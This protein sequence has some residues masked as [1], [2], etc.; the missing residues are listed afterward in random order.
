MDD[1]LTREISNLDIHIDRTLC[2]G[3]GNCVNVAPE[4]F[5]IDETNLVAFT[6]DTPDIEQDRLVEACTVCPVD[7][8]GAT[9]EEGEQLA[10]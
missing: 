5:E 1:Q 9:D 8:L 2:I 6:D 7:A 10:P 4:I 3:S